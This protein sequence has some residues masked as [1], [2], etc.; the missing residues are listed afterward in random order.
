MTVELEYRVVKVVRYIVTRYTR[1]KNIG[2]NENSGEV[3][4]RGEFDSAILAHAVAYALCRREQEILGWPIDDER[5][6]YPSGTDVA[7]PISG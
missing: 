6:K 3:E 5:I 7:N 1:N 4:Q 2:A